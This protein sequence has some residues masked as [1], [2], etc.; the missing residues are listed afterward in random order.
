MSRRYRLEILKQGLVALITGGASGL[1]KGTVETLINHGLKVV[2]VDLPSSDGAEIAKYYGENCIFIPANVKSETEIAAAFDGLHK[3]FGKVDIIV[4]CAGIYRTGK[5]YNVMTNQMQSSEEIKEIFNVNL[6]GTL[7]V[8]R[9]ACKSMLENEKDLTGQRGVIINVSSVCAFDGAIAS[10][11]LPLAGS[12]GE[13]GIRFMCIA[14]GIFDTP[15]TRPQKEKNKS[16]LVYVPFPKRYGDPLEFGSLV[17]SI[18]KN[19][20][21]NGEVIRIDGG[22]HFM[23]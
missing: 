14:P 17:Y 3:H 13:N 12:F 23:P 10:L 21:L 11:T 4:N 5:F 19:R 22:F 7:N 8:I 20:Y 1:G 15:M 9:F 16:K 18:I 2:I 6:I